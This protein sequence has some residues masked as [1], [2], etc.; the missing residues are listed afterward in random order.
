MTGFGKFGRCN[1]FRIFFRFWQIDGDFK[2]TVGSFCLKGNILRNGF[3]FYVI[4][5][6]RE[7]IE[8]RNRVFFGLTVGLPETMVDLT[9]ARDDPIHQLCTQAVLG[10]HT[11]LDLAI[12]NSDLYQLIFE[13]NQLFFLGWSI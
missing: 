12:C 3:D 2:R 8:I 7:G 9:R 13:R 5:A 10:G 11:I 4:I 1:V 6:L